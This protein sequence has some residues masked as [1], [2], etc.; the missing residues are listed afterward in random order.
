[1]YSTLLRLFRLEQA[2]SILKRILPGAESDHKAVNG[3]TTQFPIAQILLRISSNSLPD[4]TDG[5][6][7]FLP[8]DALYDIISADVVLE[9]LQSR[10][11]LP[12][13]QRSDFAEIVGRISPAGA[14]RCGR[15][16]CTGGRITFAALLSLSKPELIDSVFQKPE[17]EICDASLPQKVWPSDGTNDLLEVL[18]ET[19]SPDELNRFL[20]FTWQ[21]RSPLM[22]KLVFRDPPTEEFEKLEYPANTTL[23][24][25]LLEDPIVLDEEET[26]G[27][28]RTTVYKI[29]VH[30]AHRQA[31]ELY[32][33]LALKISDD[34]QAKRKYKQEVMANLRIPQ[35]N[36]IVPLLAAFRH[37]GKFHLV[38]PWARGGNLADL[39]QNYS[40]PRNTVVDGQTSA[41]WYSEEWLLAE[42]LGLAEGLVAIHE[43]PTSRQIHADIKP[44]NILCFASNDD[45]DGGS[46]YLKLADF[47]EAQQVKTAT[48]T[49][50]VKRVPHTKTYRPPEHDTDEALQLNYDVWCLACVFLEFITWAIAGS[51]ALNKFEADRLDE[52]DHPK[53][54]TAKGT[55]LQDTFFKKSAG[56]LGTKETSA[57][58][59]GP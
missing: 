13:E 28:E 40:T 8:R 57:H 3:M 31:N 19:L 20:H 7:R 59:T 54:S 9:V 21:M 17:K 51:E 41:D 16:L 56:E 34:Y 48:G 47:G 45:E 50:P 33:D 42:C 14:C 24:W 49:I 23:P 15:S 30:P 55:V 46:F 6:L 38:L 35:H 29:V 43:T 11:E 32:G 1:M 12:Q 58:Q 44:E 2:N 52:S 5:R 4:L 53:V 36:R 26:V 27:T 10:P 18:R 22:Q 37:R 39:F 25:T